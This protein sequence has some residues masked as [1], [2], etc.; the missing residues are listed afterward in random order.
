MKS[1]L[2]KH[3]SD[4]T[5]EDSINNS[6]ISDDDLPQDSFEDHAEIQDRRSHNSS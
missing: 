4:S 2:E 5:F 1:D 3:D 6:T